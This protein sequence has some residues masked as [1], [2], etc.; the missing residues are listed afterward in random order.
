MDVM[1]LKRIMCV[2]ALALAVPVFD[3]ASAQTGGKAARDQQPNLSGA[4]VQKT[5][6]MKIEFASKDE[7]RLY[8]HG[9]NKVIVI[10][11]RL[12][13]TKEAVK[14]K[15]TG[16]E[17]EAKDHV[18]EMLPPGLEFRFKWTVQDDT[19]TLEEVRGE[20]VDI[21]KSHLE[22]KYARKKKE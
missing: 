17:G 9:E 22:G 4:W 18:K 8:P 14:A 5:G 20:N 21:L 1:L 10:V 15:I 16:L 7:M 6:E 3:C 2:A 13:P 11:C 12:M 19:G